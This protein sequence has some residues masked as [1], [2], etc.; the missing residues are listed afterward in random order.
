[1]N[2][3]PLCANLRCNNEG[4]IAVGNKFYCSVCVIKFDKKQK[5][6]LKNEM[7]EL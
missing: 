5:E 2:K 1:M 3:R 6:K 4:W 7:E